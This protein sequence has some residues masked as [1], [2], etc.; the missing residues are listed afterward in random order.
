[1]PYIKQPTFGVFALLNWWKKTDQ[2]P[3]LPRS[4]E[5][6]DSLASPTGAC[7]HLA[8]RNVAP[9]FAGVQNGVVGAS[10]KIAQMVCNINITM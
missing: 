7:H 4:Q 9:A 8:P 6:P 10:S 5:A 3:S 1:M 2:N